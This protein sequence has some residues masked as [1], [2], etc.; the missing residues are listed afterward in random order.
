[1]TRHQL[2][3]RPLFSLHHHH[4]MGKVHESTEWAVMLHYCI[5]P[6]L[7][8]LWGNLQ[9]KII[10]SAHK[11]IG[12]QSPSSGSDWMMIFDVKR[13]NELCLHICTRLFPATTLLWDAKRVWVEQLRL[14]KTYQNT[15]QHT[16][17]MQWNLARQDLAPSKQSF[18]YLVLQVSFRPGVYRKRCTCPWAQI[19]RLGTNIYTFSAEVAGVFHHVVLSVEK[20]L[21]IYVK[22]NYFFFYKL[23]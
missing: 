16:T 11:I 14:S 10:F 20:K 12:W 17:S 13:C 6:S 23:F 4:F 8:V 7:N 2:L 22:Q 1:M 3:L 21:K 15:T 5:L 18:I 19:I 9:K